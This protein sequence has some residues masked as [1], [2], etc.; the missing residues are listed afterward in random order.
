[1]NKV[2]LPAYSVCTYPKWEAYG[3]FILVPRFLLADSAMIVLS[4]WLN[5]RV[6][7]IAEHLGTRGFESCHLLHGSENCYRKD[8]GQSKHLNIFTD[9]FNLIRI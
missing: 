5:S 4:S 9:I 1:M 6:S 8:A 3:F 2:S 7:V